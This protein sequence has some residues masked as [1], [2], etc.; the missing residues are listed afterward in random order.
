MARASHFSGLALAFWSLQLQ[1]GSETLANTC[2]DTSLFSNSWP[3]NCP[4]T[5]CILMNL[6]C[7]DAYTGLSQISLTTTSDFTS[8]I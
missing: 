5:N 2:A 4:I 1:S 7:V 3:S 8:S 6:G